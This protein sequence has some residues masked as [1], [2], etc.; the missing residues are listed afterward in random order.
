[1]NLQFQFKKNEEFRAIM[2]N[3]PYM[4]GMNGTVFIELSDVANIEKD[5]AGNVSTNTKIGDV[6]GNVS[7]R[8]KCYK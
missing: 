5:V 8:K 4:G 2:Q 7:T 6:A 1:M 3:M